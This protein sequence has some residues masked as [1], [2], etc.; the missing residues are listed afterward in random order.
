MQGHLERGEGREEDN[1]S[2]MTKRFKMGITQDGRSEGGG[3]VG[4]IRGLNNKR[5]GGRGKRRALGE[6][7]SGE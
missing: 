1:S 2:F 4:R 3:G 7:K 6:A 5:G